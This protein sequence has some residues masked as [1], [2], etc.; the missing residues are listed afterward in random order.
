MKII[1]E[2]NEPAD[3][4]HSI[5]AEDMTVADLVEQLKTFPQDA[6]VKAA[7]SS[8]TYSTT[9]GIACWPHCLVIAGE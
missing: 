9:I 7:D 4:Y 3:S 1:E 5:T 6:K 2:K 8:A